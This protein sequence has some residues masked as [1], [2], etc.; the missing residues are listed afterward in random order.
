MDT[1]L[2]WFA[3][4]ALLVL[5]GIVG[6]VLPVL[7]GTPLLLAGLVLAAW[8]ENFAY[9]GWGWLALLGAIA[10]LGYFIDFAAG[11]F[12]AKR[13]G[14]SRAG[15]I[16]AALGAFGGLFFGLP[17]VLLGPFLGAV[18]GEVLVARKQPEAAGRAG[19]GAVLGLAFGAAAKLA[20][21]FT[22]LGIFLLVRFFG[23]LG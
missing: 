23:A 21:A 10:F 4:A 20:L 5:L 22:M 2:L 11:A 12:G 13:F 15:I 16:G 14:A 9:V 8:A 18:A 7:P 19:V 1:Q 3:L 17:G 6:L